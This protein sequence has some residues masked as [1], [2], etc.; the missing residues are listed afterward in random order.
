MVVLKTRKTIFLCGIL[1]CVSLQANLRTEL[2]VISDL[3]GTECQVQYPSNSVNN[4]RQLLSHG[5]VEKIL[6]PGDVVHGECLSSVGS[7]ISYPSTVDKMWH[8][9][10]ELFL[11]V[12]T[13][14]NIFFTLSPG[15]HD[16]PGYINKKAFQVERLGFEKFWKAKEQEIR[17]DR[18]VLSDQKDKYPYY[19][20][21]VYKNNLY[22]VLESTITSNLTDRVAQKKWLKALLASPQR[23]SATS[24]V[25]MGH[26]P[27]YPVLNKSERKYDSVLIN[28][29]VGK[30]NSQDTSNGVRSLM[31]MLLDAGVDLLVVAHSHA[32]YPG[33]LRRLSDNKKIKILS[34]PCSH[35]PRKLF[36]QGAASPRGHSR[37][38]IDHTGA[39]K[40][41]VYSEARG[42]KL[43]YSFF[44]KK[45]ILQDSKVEYSL[46]D[47]ADYL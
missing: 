22:I 12:L 47:E 2:G 16:A 18:V 8:K 45:I 33:V 25:A 30:I 38:S 31:D 19:W 9:F 5:K 40:I 17:Y 35:A 10:N 7:S 32:P 27:P 39:I 15:N 46:I 44:P 42:E 6:A 14:E 34:S 29:Q 24:V 26:V 1:V 13:R 21:Y 4:F 28:E 11:S 36:G 37:V 20:A 3:N 43:P 41:G 23:A